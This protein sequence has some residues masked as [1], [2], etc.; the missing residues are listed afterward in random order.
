MRR[1]V[2]QLS[3]PSVVRENQVGPREAG[4]FSNW[5]GFALSLGPASRSQTA[6][7]KFE[8]FGS[9]VSVFLSLSTLGFSPRLSVIG[10]PQVAPPSVER[11]TSMA[12][13][14]RPKPPGFV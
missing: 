1:A 4:A 14:W 10:S 13:G 12:F 9:A 11:I 2:C 5:L 6:Y 8:S 3:P 7:A